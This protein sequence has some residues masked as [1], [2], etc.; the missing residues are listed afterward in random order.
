VI[1]F[2]KKILKHHECKAHESRAKLPLYVIIKLTSN[3]ASS[4][5]AQWNIFPNQ[6][7]LP[8]Q[9]PAKCPPPY[10]LQYLWTAKD[11]GPVFHNKM[12]M[13][14]LIMW[15][16]II[17]L[18]EYKVQKEGTGIYYMLFSKPRRVV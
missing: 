2:Y 6:G 18:S 7:I 9:G 14:L 16:E 12:G 13:G 3:F 1:Q 10:C 11:S 17:N 5:F 4:K 8:S 15:Q